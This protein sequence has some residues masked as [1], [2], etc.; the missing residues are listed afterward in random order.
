[1]FEYLAQVTRLNVV[2]LAALARAP[3]PPKGV[4]LEGAVT[5]NTTVKWETPQAGVA[6]Y[7]VWRRGT[8]DPQWR[9]GHDV[10]AD[11]TDA[12]RVQFRNVVIDDSFFG[13]SAVSADGYESP[14]VSAGE[15]GAF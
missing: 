7:R 6:R 5:P 14:V 9:I 4:T 8:T 3:A 12:G 10:A 11:A 2:T 15:S 1:D 13:V